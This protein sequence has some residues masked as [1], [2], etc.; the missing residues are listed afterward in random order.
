MKVPFSIH[1]GFLAG[2]LRDK[3]KNFD[4]KN[5]V[6]IIECTVRY[7]IL[8][9]PHIFRRIF[10]PSSNITAITVTINWNDISRTKLKEIWDSCNHLNDVRWI[11]RFTI[12]LFLLIKNA[13]LYQMAWR[14]L[15]I[16][17]RVYT[18]HFVHYPISCT[19]MI[20]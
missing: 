14:T 4:F 19:F 6:I 7:E 15:R 12:E 20:F 11:E 18:I 8:I 9:I 5:T 16:L 13:N 1:I 3:K 2:A 10:Q 17:V